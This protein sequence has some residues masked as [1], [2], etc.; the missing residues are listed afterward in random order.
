MNNIFLKGN[1]INR[2]E[3]KENKKEKNAQITDHY[4]SYYVSTYIVIFSMLAVIIENIYYVIF[5]N[6]KADI[7]RALV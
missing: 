6:N 1:N 3:K 5:I 7:L 4:A 2:S